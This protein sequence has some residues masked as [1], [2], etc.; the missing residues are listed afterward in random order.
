MRHRL[1][2]KKLGRNHHQRQALLRNLTRSLFTHGSI[3][4]TSARAK[5]VIPLVEKLAH[6]LVTEPESS[7]KMAAAPYFPGISAVNRLYRSFRETFS[8]TT[9]NFIKVA[10]L[11]RRQGDDALIVKVSFVKAYQLPALV[12]PAKIKKPVKPVK[13]KVKK[14]KN[15]K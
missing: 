7:A 15:E 1:F 4:T 13:E 6:Q 5:A 9:S 14:E 3:C 11:H 12:K 8:G 2:G 10:N